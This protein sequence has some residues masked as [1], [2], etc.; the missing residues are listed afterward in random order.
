MKTK[1]YMGEAAVIIAAALWGCIGIFTRNMFSAGFLPLQVIMVRAT[2]TFASV[3]FIMLFLNPSFLKIK[4]CDIWMFLGTGIFSFLFFNVCY[5][6]SMKHNSLSVAC[7]LMYTSPIWVSAISAVL[8]KEKFTRHKF[9]SLLLCFL[10]TVLT[11]VCAD[12]VMTGKGL[13]YGLLSGIGYALYSIFGKFAAE[14]YH[15]LTITFYTFLFAA[16][17]AL[18]LCNIKVLANL[19]VQPEN[20]WYSVGIAVFIT[21]I[22]YFLYTF[23]LSQ[24][25]AGKAAVLAIIE[26]VVAT[27]VGV[28]VYDER[29]GYIGALGIVLVALGLIYLNKNNE[30][31]EKENNNEF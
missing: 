4:L 24:I 7:I 31:K 8:F 22:P 14:K 21:V 27:L 28:F 6:N 19:M 17:G 16:L 23:G 5:L 3:F 11:C 1:K 20:I 13:V 18:P 25:K 2:I 26:P 10:G 30:N 15:S 12:F 29:I 9:V